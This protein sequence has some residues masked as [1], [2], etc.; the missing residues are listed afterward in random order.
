MERGTNLKGTFYE[1]Y[2][3]GITISLLAI[4]IGMEYIYIFFDNYYGYFDK[5]CD[6]IRK[7]KTTDKA[8]KVFAMIFSYF[9]YLLAYF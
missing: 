6:V 2:C 7:K 1:L 5:K 8:C 9:E 3:K 4:Y